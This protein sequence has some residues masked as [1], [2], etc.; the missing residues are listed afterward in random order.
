MTVTDRFSDDAPSG[1]GFPGHGENAPLELP[2]HLAASALSRIL[3]RTHEA[4]AD[5]L[6]AVGNCA[7][8]I[9][10]TGST[11]TL[12]RATGEVLSSW[13][14]DQAPLGALY[15]PCGNRRAEVCLACS[16]VYARDTFAMIRAGVA[17]GK[18]IPTTVATNPLL[19]V[20]LTAPSFGLVHGVRENG[21][22][23]RPRSSDRVEVCPHGVRLSCH[24]THADDDA[25][26]GSPLCWDCYDWTSAVVWQWHAPEL[27]RRTTIA[28]RRALA[29]ALGVPPSRLKDRASL[30]YAKVAEYQ[31]RGLVH[32][33][34]LIRLDGPDGPGSPA[35]LDAETLADLVTTV[36][37]SVTCPAPP[38]SET[39]TARVI[40][41]GRQLD[42]RTVRHHATARRSE[43]LSAGQVA[44]YLAKYATKDASSGG[45]STR[46]HVAR[47][48]Q[49]CRDLGALA[50]RRHVLGHHRKGS[51]VV[52]LDP[53]TG[54][55]HYALMG[56]WAH[57][58]GFR[59]HFSSK[60]RRYSVT[61]GQLRRARQR[62]RRLLDQAAREGK[63]LD[64][65][66]LEARLLAAEE[67]DTTLVVGDWRFSGT[68]WPRIGDEALAIAAAARAREYAQWKAA[69]R[70]NH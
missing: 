23:C 17:G 33:H 11:M 56:K 63:A 60:S 21:K 54:R 5:T 69:R 7:H 1:S 12:D 8:P 38:T 68:G 45:L 47:L 66:D 55:D 13:S 26:V 10:L 51:T 35:P 65:R 48:A 2:A 19:F 6:A 16:R 14:S 31:A 53:K 24:A 42:V 25:V 40:A 34:A 43:S 67:D 58:A 9:R 20:T 32:F 30:Q 39:D 41:W 36:T 3:D 59:G 57:M 50:T 49:V 64:T 28:L 62:Y 44:G 29:S 52:P 18:T 27:W 46:P 4:F 61:L 15:R 70:K 37:R 22:P